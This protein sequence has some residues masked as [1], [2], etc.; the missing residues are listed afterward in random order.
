[1]SD[2]RCDIQGVARVV[3]PRLRPRVADQ[4]TPPGRLVVVAAP[5]KDPTRLFELGGTLSTR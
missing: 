1:M 5:H 4:I 2:L 3:G